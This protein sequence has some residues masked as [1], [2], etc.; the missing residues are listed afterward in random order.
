[1][2][3]GCLQIVKAH[4]SLLSVA[5]TLEGEAPVNM[6]VWPDRLLQFRQSATL[7]CGGLE[8]HE[9]IGKPH[10]THDETADRGRMK[11]H[12]AAVLSRKGNA[13]HCCRP[14]GADAEPRGRKEFHCVREALPSEADLRCNGSSAG[15][16]TFSPEESS[17]LAAAI[18]K[19]GID[20]AR[21]TIGDSHGSMQ[22]LANSFRPNAENT[23]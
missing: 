8:L 11:M 10:R 7:P 21:C 12:L 9:S 6:T 3:Q 19:L 14:S 1:M 23:S 15:S 13:L 2:N 17:G 4:C 5:D 16:S 18:P 22:H 20:E